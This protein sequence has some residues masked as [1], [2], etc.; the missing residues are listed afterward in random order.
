MEIKKKS[1]HSE[2]CYVS[3]ILQ[4]F[5]KSFFNE[6]MKEHP[7]LS[8]F[9]LE[10]GNERKVHIKILSKCSL[11]AMEILMMFNIVISTHLEP[12]SSYKLTL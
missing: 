10:K 7:R 6:G 3:N 11:I 4:L 2:L 1:R 9:S 12:D 5:N 8:R